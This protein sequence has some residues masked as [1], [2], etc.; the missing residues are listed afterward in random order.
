MN[1]QV[2]SAAAPRPAKVMPYGPIPELYVSG[3]SAAKLRVE[4]ADLT[5]HDLSP[6]QICDLELQ[7][8]GGFNPLKGFL[9]EADYHG[10]VEDN[11]S[12]QVQPSYFSPVCLMCV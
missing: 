5:S 3:D 4:A 11:R 2:K 1:K 8:N 12:I 6:R 7:M 10:V 9:S